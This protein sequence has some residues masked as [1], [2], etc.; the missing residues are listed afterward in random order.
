M[1][2]NSE[3]FLTKRPFGLVGLI[4]GRIRILLRDAWRALLP[5]PVEQFIPPLPNGVRL[6]PDGETLEVVFP[7]EETPTL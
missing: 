1:R 7:Q 4:A 3:H 6:H 5:N 2:G